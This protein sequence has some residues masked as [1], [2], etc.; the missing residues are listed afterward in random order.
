M[1][2]VLVTG[3]YGGMG[4]ATAKALANAG[5]HVFALDRKV[6]EAE[7]NII[8]IELDI[9]SPESVTAAFDAVRKHTDSLCAI[10]HFAGMYMLDSLVEMSHESFRQIFEVNLYGA[11]LVNK[12]F[13]PLLWWVSCRCS[14]TNF[15]VR[16]RVC[17]PGIWQASLRRNRQRP[18]A[19]LPT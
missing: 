9:T 1:N 12:A 13:L 7:E 8:P 11:F 19:S 4:Y 6:C 3:A 10:V 18:L 14:Y 5:F 17:L 2:A 16:C 15:V